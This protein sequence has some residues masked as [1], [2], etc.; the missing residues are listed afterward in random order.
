MFSFILNRKIRI[1]KGKFIRIRK[2]II[3]YYGNTVEYN[4]RKKEW[5]PID[6]RKAN[7]ILI[8]IPST[9]EQIISP[10]IDNTLF[11]QFTDSDNN[12]LTIEAPAPEEHEE[13]KKGKSKNK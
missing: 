12:C 13:E 9:F 7:N 2:A 8:T 4:K 3:K 11:L 5:I 10:I 6:K 1:G